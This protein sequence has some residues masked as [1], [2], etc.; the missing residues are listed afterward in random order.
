MQ[1]VSSTIDEL[2]RSESRRVLATLIRALGDFDLAEDAMQ[3]AF[4]AATS[5]WES[6]GIPD[7]PVAW[8]ISAGRFR[9]IDLIRREAR[10]RELQPDIVSRVEEIASRNTIT[11]GHDIK[12]D[13]LRLIFTCCH[14]AIDPKVQVPLTLREV[15]GLSTE[16]IADAFLT[17]PA[18]MAQRIVRGKAKIRQCRDSVCHSFTRGASRTESMLCCRSSIS[19][20]TKAIQRQRAAN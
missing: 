4:V 9:A 19:S 16:E 12:D 20:S 17:S 5:D 11:S 13:Q 1:D 15:C 10:F 14:P 8:L 6:N 7:D 3:E 2:F 18:T